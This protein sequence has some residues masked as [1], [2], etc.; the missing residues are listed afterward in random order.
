MIGVGLE[1]PSARGRKGASK[2]VQLPALEQLPLKSHL[3]N[4]ASHPY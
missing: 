1:N 4:E 3:N 2:R